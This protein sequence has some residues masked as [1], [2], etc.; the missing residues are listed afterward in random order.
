VTLKNTVVASTLIQGG[1]AS[2]SPI[3][4]D[5]ESVDFDDTACPNFLGGR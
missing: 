4:D 1:C 2:C 3:T 5:G